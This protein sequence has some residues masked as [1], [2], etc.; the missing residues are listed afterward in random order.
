MRSS[1]NIF[2][3][4]G[5]DTLAQFLI[6]DIQLAG[7]NPQTEALV[8]NIVSTPGGDIHEGLAIYDALKLFKATTGK[9][10]ITRGS[11]FVGSISSVIFMAGDE[12]EL[13]E[14]TTFYIHNPSVSRVSGEADD[15]RKI[16]DFMDDQKEQAKKIY[17]SGTNVSDDDIHLLMNEEVYLSANEALSLGFATTVLHLSEM[18][19]QNNI[20]MNFKESFKKIFPNMGESNE[21]TLLALH[22]K[23]GTTANINTTNNTPSVG[24]S[25]TVN[26]ETIT[27]GDHETQS[28]FMLSVS[29]GK[30]TAVNRLEVTNESVLETIMAGFRELKAELKQ[31]REELEERTTDLEVATLQLA[32]QNHSNGFNQ[33]KPGFAKRPGEGAQT[34][35][36]APEMKHETVVQTMRT[37]QNRVAAAK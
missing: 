35:K 28:G 16:A 3:V 19:L 24:D 25:V 10:V 17:L 4:I 9:K 27:D 22:L 33:P 14:S 29:G 26:G 7:E 36:Q 1:I 15:L 11:G 30:I 31:T 34:H 12:R 32:R 13:T 23:D 6:P 21:P 20:K 5:A 2:G 37:I 18:L 8:V